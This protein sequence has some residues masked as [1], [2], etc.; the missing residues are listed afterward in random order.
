[1]NTPHADNVANASVAAK[2]AKFPLWLFVANVTKLID[3]VSGTFRIA[4]SWAAFVRT[5]GWRSGM[6]DF[7]AE[8]RREARRAPYIGAPQ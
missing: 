1:M 3:R 8:T 7:S 2:I 4:V 6:G 5:S